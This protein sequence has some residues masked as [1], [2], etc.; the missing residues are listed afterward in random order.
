MK[1]KTVAHRDGTVTYWDRTLKDFVRTL[2]K[3]IP[4]RSIKL[5]Q[6]KDQERIIRARS[7]MK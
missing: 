4:M 2:V 6:N 1:K 5:I 3:N 7:R